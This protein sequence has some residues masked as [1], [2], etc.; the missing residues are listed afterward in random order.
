MRAGG[1]ATRIILLVVLLGVAAY[2]GI[3]IWNAAYDPVKTIPVGEYT[4]EDTIP[5]GGLFIRDELLIISRG[6]IV[7]LA[8][9][10]GER[11]A[12]SQAVAAIYEDDTVMA[13]KKE[14]AALDAQIALL[15]YTDRRS[16]DAANTTK[17]DAQISSQLLEILEALSDRD[18]LGQEGRTLEFKSLILKRSLVYSSD[19]DALAGRMAALR[20]QRD[21]LAAQLSSGIE[22]VYTDDSGTFSAFTDGYE[23]ILVPEILETLTPAQFDAL[24]SLRENLAE[25]VFLGK[26]IRGFRWYY[27]AVLPNE[28]ASLLTEGRRVRVR[29]HN[30]YGGDL[31]MTLTS[32]RAG[33]DGRTVLIFES[34][35]AMS[36]TTML[37]SQSAEIIY[38]TYSGIKIPRSAIRVTEEGVTGVYCSI[39]LQARFR[40]VEIIYWGDNFYIVAYDPAKSGSL[41][42]GDEVYVSGRDLYDGK[43]MK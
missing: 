28:T 31:I 11:V 22:Y 24:P 10:E 43:I 26:L 42:P 37:R 33:E 36:E 2:F 1:I 29:V 12:R 40:E 41:R 21:E 23:N 32:K 5:L 39:G 15:E 8:I 34:M 7:D 6:G 30:D 38:R 14:I 20:A 17:L 25:G 13:T 16:A 27:A 18:L 35:D 9:G 19:P 3:Y 4:V